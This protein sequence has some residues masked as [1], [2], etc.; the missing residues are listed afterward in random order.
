MTKLPLHSIQKKMIFFQVPGTYY[1]ID[2]QKIQLISDQVQLFQYAISHHVWRSL[3][4]TLVDKSKFDL[5]HFDTRYTILDPH[6]AWRSLD[7]T[8][9]ISSPFVRAFYL[10]F[11]K[12]ATF[13]KHASFLLNWV[14]CPVICPVI[15]PIIRGHLVIC[16]V[17]R[18]LHCLFIRLGIPTLISS[19]I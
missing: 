14:I 9:D 7:P 12:D 6:H 3:D 16:P 15:R 1:R 8:L 17:I 5:C 2:V 18:C 19:F 10:L 4:P 11:L 13:S